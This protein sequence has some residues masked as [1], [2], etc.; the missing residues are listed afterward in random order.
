MEDT[1]PRLP[2]QLP[3]LHLARELLARIDDAAMLQ[4]TLAQVSAEAVLREKLGQ[5]E[6]AIQS[7]CEVKVWVERRLGEV[8]AA[9][10]DDG[11]LMRGQP[12]EMSERK[13][14]PDLGISRDES[15]R[16]QRLAALPEEEV[17]QRIEAVKSSAQR[18]T[19]P[20]VLRPFRAAAVAAVGAELES[21]PELQ[22]ARTRVN[23]HKAISPLFQAIGDWLTPERVVEVQDDYFAIQMQAERIQTWATKVLAEIERQSKVRVVK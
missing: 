10:K 12:R 4:A 9:M 17:E 21:D 14:L 1:D 19:T 20:R 23:A 18:L 5:S 15:S 11:R 16:Y 13:T 22:R 3:E 2:A 7:A 6:D 8:L